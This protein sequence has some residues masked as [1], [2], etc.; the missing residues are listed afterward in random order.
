ML[1]EHGLPRQ[2]EAQVPGDRSFAWQR[3][4]PPDTE[5]ARS[6]RIVGAHGIR[7]NTS[8]SGPS[9][10]ADFSFRGT[11]DLPELHTRPILRRFMSSD[12][13]SLYSRKN[14]FPALHPVNQ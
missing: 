12:P 5:Q 7:R 10:A 14:P 8:T 3:N 11:R 13:T 9:P 4:D 6:K 2:K 1:S